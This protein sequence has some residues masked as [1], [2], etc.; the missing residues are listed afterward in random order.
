M[1]RLRALKIQARLAAA[2]QEARTGTWV[3]QV[4]GN[5]KA[6][7][8]FNPIRNMERRFVDKYKSLSWVERT[9]LNKGF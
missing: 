1:K 9:K 7:M 4:P 8:R 6:S 2:S 3:V 5:S